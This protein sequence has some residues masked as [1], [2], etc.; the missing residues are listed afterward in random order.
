MYSDLAL[1]DSGFLRRAAGCADTSAPPPSPTE[2]ELKKMS[3]A[4]LMVL[5]ALA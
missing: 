4:V 2:R 3:A 5:R 1:Q